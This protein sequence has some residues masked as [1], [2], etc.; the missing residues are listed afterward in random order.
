MRFLVINILA[1][2]LCLTSCKTTV[3]FTS[4]TKE[5]CGLSDHQLKNIQ[6]YTSQKITLYKIK[7]ESS[8]QITNGR[9]VVSDR[10]DAETI[11]I[12]KGTPCVLVQTMKDVFLLSFEYGDGKLLAF[13]TTSGGAYT[14][15]AKDWD[16]TQGV[17]EYGHRMYV[18]N[19][20]KT[21]LKVNMKS[22][23]RERNKYRVVQGRTLKN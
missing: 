16:G 7:Q 8:A 15:M 12:P 9:I 10:K 1:L 21:F 2:S 22:I 13:G 18:T 5:N 19:D 4:S 23:K 17:L 11:I 20:G 6:F 14:L 3:P